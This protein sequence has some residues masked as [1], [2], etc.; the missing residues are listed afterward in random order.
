MLNILRELL[1]KSSLQT[2]KGGKMEKIVKT[3]RDKRIQIS[4]EPVKRVV[5]LQ[6]D[7]GQIIERKNFNE[8]DLIYPTR[9]VLEIESKCNSGCKYCSYQNKK[10]GPAL[11]TNLIIEA[12]DNLNKMKVLEISLRGGEATLH[13]DFDKIW[14]YATKKDFTSINLITNGLTINKKKIDKLLKN[15]SAKLITSLD[16]F[17]ST[18]NIR[19]PKQYE[20]VMKWLPYA[21][22]RYPHQ[23]V[24]LTCLY[25]QTAKEALTF[26][27]FLAEQGLL[28]HN[29]PVL[30][31]QGHAYSFSNTEFLTKKEMIGLQTSLDFIKDE[32]PNFRPIISC[33]E[34][35]E[36]SYQIMKDIPVPLFNDIYISQTLRITTS[37]EVKIMSGGHFDDNFFDSIPEDDYLGPLGNIKNDSISNIWL[38]TIKI[39]KQQVKIAYRYF[40]FFLG[41]KKSLTDC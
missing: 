6:D 16:G 41:W 13:K 18:N 9:A 25:K 33:G 39:R 15:P 38:K 34:I 10:H 31:R 20:K 24:I 19:N 17:P 4:F 32:F 7:Y 40:P 36:K 12:I 21:L 22:E 8:W 14:K 27:H 37:G 26:S 35:H 5:T 23:I 3:R 1:L 28:Y 11:A 30:K 2:N 29:F